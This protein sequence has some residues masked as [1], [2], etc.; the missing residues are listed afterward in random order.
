MNKTEKV[1]NHLIEKGS[2]T[3][4]EAIKLYGSIRLSSIIYNLRYRY[5]MEIESEKVKFVDRFGDK[6]SY[7]RYILK[8][9]KNE[10]KI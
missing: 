2:I 1:R 3:S 8:E 5:N 4:W 10:K 7:A 6:S 9:N